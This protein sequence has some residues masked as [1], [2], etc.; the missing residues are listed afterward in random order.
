MLA[1]G[2]MNSVY[3]F[4]KINTNVFFLN[5][6]FDAVCPLDNTDLAESQVSDLSFVIN[7]YIP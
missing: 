2:F 7:V 3:T 1:P 5:R 4:D 6:K